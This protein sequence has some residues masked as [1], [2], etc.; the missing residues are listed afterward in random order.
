MGVLM[1]ELSQKRSEPGLMFGLSEGR[2]HQEVVITS[3]ARDLL[4]A[5]AA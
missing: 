4:F 1:L 2:R 5:C 3:E